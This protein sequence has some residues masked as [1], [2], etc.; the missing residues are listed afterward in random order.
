V[1]HLKSQSPPPQ[2]PNKLIN[3]TISNYIEDIS[4]N[5][6]EE[7]VKLHDFKSFESEDISSFLNSE[8]FKSLLPTTDINIEELKLLILK[9]FKNPTPEK[10]PTGELID[11]I[12]DF[13]SRNILTLAARPVVSLEH[14][15]EKEDI[16]ESAKL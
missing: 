10:Y 7:L 1:V 9:D 3:I 5:K 4:S 16:N 8:D 14:F 11:S 13:K 2:E 6:L 15:V 12:S